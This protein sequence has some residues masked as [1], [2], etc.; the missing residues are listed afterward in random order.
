MGQ[1]AKFVKQLEDAI[2]AKNQAA[3]TE[4]QIFKAFK[5]R[6]GLHAELGNRDAAIKKQSFS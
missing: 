3:N 2:K 4:E 6:F 5:K 1:I